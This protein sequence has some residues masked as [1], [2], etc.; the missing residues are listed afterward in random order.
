MVW[1]KI[2][3]PFNFK[4][5][6]KDVTVSGLANF[7]ETRDRNCKFLWIVANVICISAAVA[8]CYNSVAHYLKFEVKTTMKVIG[9][10]SNPNFPAITFCTTSSTR[11][12]YRSNSDEYAEAYYILMASWNPGEVEKAKT[13]AIKVP[14]TLGHECMQNLTSKKQ[15]FNIVVDTPNI[16]DHI[17]LVSTV[18]E[19]MGT[20]DKYL[21]LGDRFKGCSP[22]DDEERVQ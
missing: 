11:T 7:L 16:I 13:F 14:R 6:C 2:E 10:D 21:A 8:L 9:Q 22:R 5:F 12:S 17:D 18:W 15:Y 1:L 3:R 20:K 19:G 4:S